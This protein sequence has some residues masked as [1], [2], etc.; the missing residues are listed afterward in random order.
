[1]NVVESVYMY[2][3]Y[4]SKIGIGIYCV[5]CKIKLCKITIKGINC[6]NASSVCLEENVLESIFYLVQKIYKYTVSIHTVAWLLKLQSCCLPNCTRQGLVY[7]QKILPFVI[8]IFIRAQDKKSDKLLYF[9][10]ILALCL[11]CLVP[12]VNFET[13]SF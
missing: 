7:S 5:S 10:A 1:M 3:M 2:I 12:I 6:V 8:N 4:N 13:L 9:P 11:V